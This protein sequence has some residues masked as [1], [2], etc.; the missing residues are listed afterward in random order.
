MV[1]S[2]GNRPT[3]Q[4]PQPHVRASGVGVGAGRAGA[5]STAVSK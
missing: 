3:A 1:V 5:I 4:D 2:G